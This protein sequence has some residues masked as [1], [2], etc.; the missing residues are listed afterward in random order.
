MLRLGFFIEDQLKKQ[1]GAWKWN[2][3]MSTRRRQT[4]SNTLPKLLISI[5]VVAGLG[6]LIYGLANS[7]GW[8]SP[9]P[10]SNVAR[11]SREGKVAV[12]KALVA[13]KA[14]EKVRREDVYDRE[15]DDESFFWLSEEDVENNPDWV[16]SLDQIINRVMARDKRKDF[17]FKKSDFLPEGSRTGIIAGVPAGKQ[18]FFLEVE[19]IPG[20]RFLKQGDRFDLI[21]SLP[22]ESEDSGS[23]FGLLMGGFK[24]RGNKPIPVN[25]IRLLAK[26]AH[27]IALTTDRTMTT[28]GGLELNNTDSRGRVAAGQRE[29]SVAIAIDPE[30]AIPLTQALGDDLEIHMVAQ[31]GQTDENGATEINLG[32]F[33]SFPANAIKI[34]AFE[35]IKASDLAEPVSGDLRRYFFKPSAVVDG[36]IPSPNDLIGKTVSHDIEPG[37]IFSASDFLPTGSLIQE[38]SAFETITSEMLVSGNADPNSLQF[39]GAVAARDLK[40]GHLVTQND[41]LPEGSLIQDVVAFEPI[42]QSDLASPNDSPWI[43]RY[44]SKRLEKGHQVTEEDVLSSNSALRK[45]ASFQQ[46]TS[47]DLVDGNRSPWLGRIASKDIEPGQDIDENLLFQKGAR[48]GTS[49]G[50][51]KGRVA[52]SVDSDA[53][54]GIGD[55]TTGDRVDLIKSSVVDLKKSLAGIQVSGALLASTDQ[56]SFTQVVASNALVV[57][58]LEDQYV[59]AVRVGEV[60]NLVKSLALETELIAIARP[61]TPATM[62]KVSPF[63][64]PDELT[65]GLQSEPNPLSNV[66]VTEMIVGGKKTAR[67]FRRKDDE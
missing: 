67:A 37:Y 25:G 44:A 21:A 12:P 20:L 7:M 63:D 29:E 55:L 50:I 11:P 24:V 59:L 1:E 45:I 17:V 19:K 14:F 35:K 33:V 38:V 61:D 43:G 36:W 47:A 27:M 39:V 18:G 9:S 3:N 32:E 42:G 60:S 6:V 64:K 58:K 57:R 26:G 48:A 16:T 10:E 54:K 51:P 23:E 13:L 46:L 40:S 31:S 30:E 8:L 66:V 28:Q 15:L 22:K 4:Q 49:A 41:I 52:V 56:Q 5:L 2:L 53:V 62:E 65:D 34:N